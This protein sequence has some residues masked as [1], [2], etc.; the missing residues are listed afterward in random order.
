MTI[1]LSPSDKDTIIYQKDNSKK[2]LA[3]LRAESSEGKSS[4]I[5]YI[6]RLISR[7]KYKKAGFNHER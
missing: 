2:Q 1:I 3:S 5:Y 7:Q 6:S 4:E